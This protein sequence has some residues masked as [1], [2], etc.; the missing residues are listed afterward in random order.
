MDIDSEQLAYWYL[1]L[2]GF[3][4]IP[5][6]VVHPDS[7]KNQETDVDVLGVRLPFRAENISRPMRDA[8]LFTRKR[9]KTYLIIAEVKSGLC[10]L[11]GPW[12]KPERQ[13]MQRVLMAV[14]AFT[15]AETEIVAKALY[16]VGKYTNQLYH[17]SLAC[18]GRDRNDEISQK[19]PDVP[20]ILWNEVL[21]F[22][23][24]RF[25]EY[26]KTKIS[27]PQWDQDGRNLWN[28]YAAHPRD[29]IQFASSIR[30]S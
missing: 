14:G 16:E 11:N 12:T 18:L 27:H 6:F 2:N 29:A 5:N 10:L 15:K 24:Q 1:R 7:G 13:N 20:Q 28:Q 17:V 26:R 21:T 25:S 3:L 4:T 8:D 9:D 30:V 23:H 22:I 19:Y